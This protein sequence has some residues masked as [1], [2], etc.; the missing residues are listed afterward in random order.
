MIYLGFNSSMLVDLLDL[1]SPSV[2]AIW[3]VPWLISRMVLVILL[4]SLL[5]LSIFSSKDFS[6]SVVSDTA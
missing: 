6:C 3:S 2:L 1:P 5:T 4:A